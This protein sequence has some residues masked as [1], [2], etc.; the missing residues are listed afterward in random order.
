MRGDPPELVEEGTTEADGVAAGVF[1]LPDTKLASMAL[2][3]MLTGVNTWYRDGGRLGR[4]EVQAIYRDMV[5]G[6]VGA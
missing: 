5:R 3:A 1:R 4:D 2:I 6:A